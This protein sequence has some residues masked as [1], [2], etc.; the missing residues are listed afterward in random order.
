MLPA[1]P[2]QGISAVSD[3]DLSP[4]E[5]THV[6]E[7]IYFTGHSE[8]SGRELYR[9]NPESEPIDIQLIELLPGEKSSF[10]RVP[11]LS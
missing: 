9:F 7:F 1:V 2:A 8:E 6:G 10:P 5:I 4:R 11:L 3:D